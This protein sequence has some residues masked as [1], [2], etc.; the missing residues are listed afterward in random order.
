MQIKDFEKAAKVEL[1]QEDQ[2]MAK[3]EIKERLKEIRI[4]ER[5]LEKLKRKYISFL[6]KDVDE[7]P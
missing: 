4:A 1:E 5:I 7:L 2:Q 3:E 6:E